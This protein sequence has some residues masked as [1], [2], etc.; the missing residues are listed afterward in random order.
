MDKMTTHERLK[1]SHPT[2]RKSCGEPQYTLAEATH[3]V[4]LFIRMLRRGEPLVP[5][6]C[7]E[8]GEMSTPARNSVARLERDML[9]V[10]YT[11]LLDQNPDFEYEL[12]EID[13]RDD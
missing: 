13:W 5:N 1:E 12:G 11:Y 4:S 9:N 10:V 8:Y 6:G 3:W 7:N 2:P